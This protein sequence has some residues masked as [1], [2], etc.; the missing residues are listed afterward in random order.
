MLLLTEFF[1]C[2]LRQISTIITDDTMRIS[3]TKDHLFD[4]LNRRG[5]V[6]FTDWL[7]LNPLC[8]FINCYQEVSLFILRPFERP[9]HIQPLD[10]KRPSNWNHPHFLSRHMSSS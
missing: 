10:C 6:T 2:P 5:R 7:S 8:K 3:K 1:H 4:E 9:N